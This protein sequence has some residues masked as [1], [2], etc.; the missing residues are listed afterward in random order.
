MTGNAVIAGGTG[1][2]AGATGKLKVTGSFSIKST[3]AGTSEKSA[4]TLTLT[5]NINTK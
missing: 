4:L 5:G 3:D 2:F 1:K